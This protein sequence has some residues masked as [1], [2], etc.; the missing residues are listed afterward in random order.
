MKVPMIIS[1]A[2]APA[3]LTD[4]CTV[5]IL[6]S[7]HERVA[8]L[9]DVWKVDYKIQDTRPIFELKLKRSLKPSEW[10]DDNTLFN[11]LRNAANPPF[12]EIWVNPFCEIGIVNEIEIQ[13]Q[14][15]V[16]NYS[17][18]LPCKLVVCTATVNKV[19]IM[20]KFRQVEEKSENFT[21]RE[22]RNAL[23]IALDN[24]VSNVFP[25]LFV[26]FKVTTGGGG[27]VKRTWE[28]IGSQLLL[29]L[30]DAE[31]KGVPAQKKCMEILAQLHKC[32][33]V[34]GD[35]HMKNF[36]KVPGIGG[37]RNGLPNIRLIDL[38]EVRVIP[39]DQVRVG[40][41]L[42]ILDYQS[43]MFWNNPRFK[44]FQ[45]IYY[46]NGGNNHAMLHR[47]YNRAWRD[48]TDSDIEIAFGP[49]PFNDQKGRSVADLQK[50]LMDP[51]IATKGGKTF[52]N[53]LVSLDP[54]SIRVKFNAILNDSTMW[55]KIEERLLVA[56][57]KEDPKVAPPLVVVK[58]GPRKKGG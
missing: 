20:L 26:V 42:R 33:Y 53:Y 47:V 16:S 49:Y 58:P 14:V 55:G 6:E 23:Q 22:A 7:L 51:V 8:R 24:G 52:L 10:A 1:P 17:N 35:P 43:F 44:V 15:S 39:S 45:E 11:S 34:H 9:E 5:G 18:G 27:K 36:M 48:N 4:D 3:C 30:T 50:S 56:W 12:G 32:G 19:D 37:G 46:D 25:M 40:Y 54:E 21:E 13:K 28:C 38:D 57:Q 41:Y 31:K 29:E 2:R